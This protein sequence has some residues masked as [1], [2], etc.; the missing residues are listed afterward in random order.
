MNRKFRKITNKMP[1]LLLFF[2]NDLI[3]AQSPTDGYQVFQHAVKW[4]TIAPADASVF[5]GP[6]T[7]KSK[8]TVEVK[9]NNQFQIQVRLIGEI[10]QKVNDFPE[11]WEVLNTQGSIFDVDEIPAGKIRTLE[12]SFSHHFKADKR[13]IHKIQLWLMI[14][15]C[16]ICGNPIIS[17][18]Q[19]GKNAY[20]FF[21]VLEQ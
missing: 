1:F 15:K 13:G 18:A 16:D 20:N 4:K 12:G 11:T 6:S 8:G 19:I 3:A 5:R 21:F 9:N 17:T 2:F 10:F 14:Y 7:V